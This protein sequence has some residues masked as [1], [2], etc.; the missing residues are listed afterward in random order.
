MAKD[1]CTPN[2]FTPSPT[3]LSAHSTSKIPFPNLPSMMLALSALVAPPICVSVH[4][5]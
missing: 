1:T 2:L 5:G 3:N 4:V